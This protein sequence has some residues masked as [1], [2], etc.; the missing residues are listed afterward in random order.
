MFRLSWKLSSSFKEAAFL[1]LY[2]VTEGTF[3]KPHPC[4]QDNMADTGSAEI[5]MELPFLYLSGALVLSCGIK[6]RRV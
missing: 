6:L 5:C 3:V 2:P 1:S 4:G